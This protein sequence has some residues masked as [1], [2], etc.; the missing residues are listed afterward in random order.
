VIVVLVAAVGLAGCGGS[1]SPSAELGQE[2]KKANAI[3][4]EKS[5]GRL[6]LQLVPAGTQAINLSRYKTLQHSLRVAFSSDKLPGGHPVKAARP[7]R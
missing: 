1:R 2:L 5:H 6:E 7:S 3:I 4:R